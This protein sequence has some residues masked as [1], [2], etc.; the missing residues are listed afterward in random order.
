MKAD[1]QVY[2]LMTSVGGVA[3]TEIPQPGG[4]AGED[5]LGFG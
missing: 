3:F 5:E 4:R 1:A 2:G